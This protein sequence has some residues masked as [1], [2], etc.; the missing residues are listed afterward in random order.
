MPNTNYLPHTADAIS[1]CPFC[2]AERARV[3]EFDVDS[4]AVVCDLCHGNGP[5]GKDEEN[6]ISHWNLRLVPKA[7]RGILRSV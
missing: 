4:W 6:A 1:A 2:G 5:S 7:T 3:L